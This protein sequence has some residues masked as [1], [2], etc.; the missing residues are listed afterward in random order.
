M[1]SCPLKSRGLFVLAEP[2]EGGRGERG[3]KIETE[4]EKETQGRGEIDGGEEVLR[5]GRRVSPVFP[6]V[7]T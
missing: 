6:H 7:K 3:R 4:R 1:H 2:R 5:G